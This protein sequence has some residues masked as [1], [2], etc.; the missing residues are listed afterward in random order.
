MFDTKKEWQKIIG[1][2]MFFLVGFWPIKP[3]VW[4]LFGPKLGPNMNFECP[5]ESI[6]GT[7]HISE[8]V[9][10]LAPLAVT[11]FSKCSERSK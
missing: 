4:L 9:I 7:K 11:K 2:I 5:R 8:D 10:L 1:F 6:G 3:T